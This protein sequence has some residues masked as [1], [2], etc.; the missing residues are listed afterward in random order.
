[1]RKFIDSN[2]FL[3]AYLKPR[4]KLSEKERKMKMLAAKIIEMVEAGEEHVV[5]TVVHL[6]EIL[7]IIEYRL[8]LK[9]SQ[10]FLETVLAMD[11]FEI[12]PVSVEDY[13][14][15]LEVSTRFTISINDAIAYIKMKKENI[16]TIYTFDKHMQNLK[17]IK[18]LPAPKQYETTRA[19]AKK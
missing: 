9:C 1:M 3:Y 17:D 5:T 10:D 8:G 6:A 11:N 19:I 4:R 7:N 16:E 15:A 12:L 13:Q 18:I 2:V 14:A